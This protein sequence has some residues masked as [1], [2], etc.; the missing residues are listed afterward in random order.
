M[1]ARI[2]VID[3]TEHIRSILTMMLKF[4]G[5]AIAEAQNGLE[6]MEAARGGSF[7]LIFCDIDMP[8]MNGVEFV[9]Q[10][11]Q[12][13]DKDTPIIMLTAEGNELISTALNVGATA[14]VKKPFEPIHLLGEIEKHLKA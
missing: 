4:K 11:R 10:Y 8:V 12:E 13:I 2:L 5:Y 6:A 7:D 14:C 3:D 1:G 9:R